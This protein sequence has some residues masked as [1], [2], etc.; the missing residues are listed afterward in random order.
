[1][2]EAHATNEPMFEVEKRRLGFT[3]ADVGQL[4]ALKWQFPAKLAEAIAHHHSPSGAAHF[5]RET[6]LVHFADIVA[7]A[8]VLGDTYDRRIPPLDPGA[9]DVLGLK[10]SQIEQ[11]MQATDEE[12]EK[13]KALL[14]IIME[15]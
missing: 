6:A 10:K 7:R 8:K 15:A 5:P 3:H 9:W 1:M 13:G 4:L 12:F 14:S 11:V 2:E